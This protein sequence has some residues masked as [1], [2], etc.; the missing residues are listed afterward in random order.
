VFAAWADLDKK[1]QWWGQT[2]EHELDFRV[3]GR[4]QL[5]VR[6]GEGVEYTFDAVYGDIVE[7]ERI[8]YSYDMHRDGTRIS[9]SVATVELLDAEGG[10]LLRFTEQGAFLDGHDEPAAR[11]HG[12]GELLDALAGALGREAQAR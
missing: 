12:T 8:I 10:T 11:E 7:D 5:R 6:T 2:D 1:R 4:E 3:G 9:V